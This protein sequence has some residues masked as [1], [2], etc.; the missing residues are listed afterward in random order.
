MANRNWLN[1]QKL[2]TNLA[3]PTMINLQFEVDPTDP[4]GIANLKSNGLVKAVYMHSSDG[5]PVGPNPA[6][7]VIVVQLQDNYASMINMESSLVSPASGSDLSVRAAD[8]ALTVGQPYV[9]SVLGAATAANWIT[10][11]VPSGITPAVGVMFIAQAT[12][13]G[14]NSVS[15]VQAITKSGISSV[16]LMGDPQAMLGPQGVSNQGAWLFLQCV[17]DSTASTAAAITAGTPSGSI[18]AGVIPVTAGTAGN[19]VTNNAGVLESSGGQDL[20]VNAQTFTGDALATHTHTITSTTSMAK[21]AP[22]TGSIINI[23]FLM[24]NSSVTVDG[25]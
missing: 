19:A 24:D 4:T 13:A 16:E 10:L 7:G 18:S 1:G 25:L 23:S 21:A 11:G 22:A 12:G 8:T 14:T 6:N 5:S 20:A 9:I 3:A 17:S 15:K 2:Y